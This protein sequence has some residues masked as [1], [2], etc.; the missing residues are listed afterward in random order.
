MIYFYFL[1]LP[2]V[3]DNDKLFCN[4]RMDIGYFIYDYI[5]VVVLKNE[6]Y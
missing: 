4:H 3:A 6:V 1:C 2:S 5:R